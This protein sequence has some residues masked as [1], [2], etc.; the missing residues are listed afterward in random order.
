MEFFSAD[1]GLHDAVQFLSQEDGQDRRRSLLSAQA[2]IIARAGHRGAERVL[3]LV[4]AL[5][6]SGE[7]QEEARVLGRGRSG[8]EQVLSCVG[9]QGPVVVLAAAVHA[10]K[11]LFVKQAVEAVPVR[12][13]FHELHSQLV[14]VA[15]QVC[16]GVDRCHL[17]LGGRHLVVFRL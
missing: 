15:R 10:G 13:P 17:M 14:L 16:V 4:H 2:V 6:E 8:V 7:E 3:V 12:H 9:A 1:D 5:H 11:G